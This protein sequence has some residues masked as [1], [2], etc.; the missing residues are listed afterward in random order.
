M[1]SKFLLQEKDC[2]MRCKVCIALGRKTLQVNCKDQIYINSKVCF[3]ITMSQPLFIKARLGWVRP[4][5]EL[6]TMETNKGTIYA[7]VIMQLL[8]LYDQFIRKRSTKTRS[9]K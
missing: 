6:L 4:Q 5:I 3:Q 9:H 8:Y 1:C 7:A 2:K